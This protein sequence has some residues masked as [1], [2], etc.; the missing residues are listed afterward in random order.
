MDVDR[1]NVFASDGEF[2]QDAP[3]GS[4]APGGAGSAKEHTV[5]ER[6]LSHRHGALQPALADALDIGGKARLVVRPRRPYL[7]QQE[8]V[9][10]GVIGVDRQGYR[11]VDEVAIEVDVFLSDAARVR[12]PIGV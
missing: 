11:K 2:P 5:L 10:V 8:I 1:S 3:E 6:V 7:R 4:V 12:E 9:N